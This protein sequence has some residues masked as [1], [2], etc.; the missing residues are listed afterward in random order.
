M[1]MQMPFKGASA[2]VNEIVKWLVDDHKKF[3]KELSS[4]ESGLKSPSGGTWGDMEKF[5]K[6]VESLSG[7]LLIEEGT[8]FPELDMLPNKYPLKIV[9]LEHDDLERITTTANRHIAG[10]VKYRDESQ[11]QS[12][13]ESTLSVIK[14][15]KRHFELEEEIIFPMIPHLATEQQEKILPRLRLVERS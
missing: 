1:Q 11:K 14:F 15:I 12:A 5:L 6:I 3:L 10:I 2:E 9:H 13:V 4:V 8:V 7:H